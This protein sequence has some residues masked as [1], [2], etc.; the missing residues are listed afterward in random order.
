[1]NERDVTSSSSIRR[2]SEPFEMV[3][4]V[5]CFRGLPVERHLLTIAG[6]DLEVIGV[7]EP[8]DLL[9][10]PDF[11]RRFIE[12]D[13]AP[14]GLELWPAACMLAEHLSKR[15]ESGDNALELGCGLGLV[16]ISAALAG[17]RIIATDNEPASLHFAR[18][19]ADLNDAPIAG[20]EMLDWREPPRDRR[21]DRIVA[22]DVLYQLVDQEPILTCLD[23]MLS[24]TGIALVSDP[25]RSVANGFESLAREHGFS[26]DVTA[27]SALS[28][29][30][31][32]V[33]GRIFR[34]RR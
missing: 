14:Y 4:G 19:N 26:V 24:G 34:L 25:N 12:E 10:Q 23:A 28:H 33:A 2:D 7:T 1:M 9:D 29:T 6:R 22:A 3:D 27:A 31:K 17:W 5:A 13:R 30:G 11:A 18:Y 16:S 20:L 8:A 32:Q 21:F 15:E